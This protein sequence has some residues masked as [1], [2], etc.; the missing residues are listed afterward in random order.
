MKY[1]S[2]PLTN[3]NAVKIMAAIM[4][5]SGITTMKLVAKT[6]VPQATTYRTVAALL[7]TGWL[8]TMHKKPGKMGRNATAMYSAKHKTIGVTISGR[9][10]HITKVP[11]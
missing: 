10:L 4:N 2:N 6:K 11:A 7:A 1:E 8:D 3:T 5:N 9:G